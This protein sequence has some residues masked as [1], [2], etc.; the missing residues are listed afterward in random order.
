MNHSKADA[1]LIRA[2]WLPGDAGLEEEFTRLATCNSCIAEATLGDETCAPLALAANT[3]I[4]IQYIREKDAVQKLILEYQVLKLP[5]LI[6]PVS[7]SRVKCE[8]KYSET[9]PY[10]REEVDVLFAQAVQAFDEFDV[11]NSARL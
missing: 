10:R 5:V 6:Y 11:F 8:L 1:I 3:L 9:L 7:S 4:D 2:S